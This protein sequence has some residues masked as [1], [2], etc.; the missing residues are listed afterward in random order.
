MSAN[1]IESFAASR[2]DYGNDLYDDL[3]LANLQGILQLHYRVSVR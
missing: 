3:V 1:A 2:L